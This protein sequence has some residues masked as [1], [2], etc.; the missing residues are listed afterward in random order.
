MDSNS[1]LYKSKFSASQTSPRHQSG[2]TSPY[3]RPNVANARNVLMPS[4]SSH[5]AKSCGYQSIIDKGR[6]ARANDE[7]LRYEQQKAKKEADSLKATKARLAADEAARR[8]AEQ[9]RLSID[10]YKGKLLD[11]ITNNVKAKIEIECR[12]EIREKVYRNYEKIASAYERQIRDETKSRLVEELEPVVM[13][14]LAAEY[15]MEIKQQ[16]ID[17]LEPVVKAELSANYETEIK[18]QLKVSLES[19]V[20]GDLRKKYLRKV[21]ADLKREHTDSVR[22]GIEN[23]MHTQN[24]FLYDQNHRVLDDHFTEH[25]NPELQYP[26]LEKYQYLNNLDENQDDGLTT[27]GPADTGCHNHQNEQDFG[28]VANVPRHIATDSL[29]DGDQSN[30][31]T[32]KETMFAGVY[33]DNE[34]VENLETKVNNSG[35]GQEPDIL[36]NGPSQEFLQTPR[37]SSPHHSQVNGQPHQMSRG[38][39]RPLSEEDGNQGKDYDRKFKRLRSTSLESDDGRQS[40]GYEDPDGEAGEDD[41]HP[42]Y[43]QEQHIY[44]GMLEDSADLLQYEKNGASRVDGSDDIRRTNGFMSDEEADGRSGSE[45]DETSEDSDI[46]SLESEFLSTAPQAAQNS[47]MGSGVISNSNTQETAFIVDDSDDEDSK[48]EDEEKTLVDYSGFQSISS[49]IKGSNHNKINEDQCSLSIQEVVLKRAAALDE[50]VMQTFTH[51]EH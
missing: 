1:S 33:T 8:L 28:N 30:V 2:M 13:A 32:Q 14:Q 37:G 7:R 18:D 51:V 24:G 29:E 9:S 22:V 21:I 19:T 43:E 31:E 49:V 4:T 17:E 34:E 45:V 25:T 20:I 41:F 47:I 27:Q 3:A 11:E 26:D 16:L 10:E 50:G 36:D 15:E 48:V 6:Q 12:V 38:T 23:D 42:S 5:D 35:G 39:K 46:D 44:R 40:S